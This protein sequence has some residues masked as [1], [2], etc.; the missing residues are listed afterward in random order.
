MQRIA[1]A[2][3]G[4][5]ESQSS[6]PKGF[7]TVE[8]AADYTSLTRQAIRSAHKQGRLKGRKGSSGRLLFAIED[9]NRFAG[10]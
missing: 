3:A 9:L 6:T 1:Q 4:I 5:L 8:A 10:G 2:L 7:M